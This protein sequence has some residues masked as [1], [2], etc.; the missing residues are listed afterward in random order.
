MLMRNVNTNDTQYY[1]IQ[2]NQVVG[3][4][5]FG[6]IGPELQV[7]GFGN[8]TGNPN[9]TDMLMRNV[10]TGA[11]QYYDIQNNHVVASGSMGAAGL[12]L[13]FLGVGVAGAPG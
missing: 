12:D 11:F 6:A 2:H 8:F 1:D 3:S 13:H 9:E 4:G 10:N 5:S 7:V